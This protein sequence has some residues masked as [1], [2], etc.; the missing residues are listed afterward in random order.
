MRQSQ[1]YFTNQ[2]PMTSPDP[3]LR[4]PFRPQPRRLTCQ[5]KTIRVRLALKEIARAINTTPDQFRM[6]GDDGNLTLT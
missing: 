2:Q 4:Q 1:N 3:Y 5:D 6:L